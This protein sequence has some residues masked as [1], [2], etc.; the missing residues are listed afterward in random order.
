L[1]LELMILQVISITES[2]TGVEVTLLEVKL[3]LL[4]LILSVENNS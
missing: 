4:K 3:K 1:I 2:I